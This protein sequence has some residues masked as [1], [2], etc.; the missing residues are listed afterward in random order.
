MMVN[1]LRERRIT[2]VE[3]ENVGFLTE[4]KEGL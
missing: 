1:W 2:N 4:F 3:L